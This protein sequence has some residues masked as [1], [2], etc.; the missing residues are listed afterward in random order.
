MNTDVSISGLPPSTANISVANAN[1]SS[2]TTPLPAT[3]HSA[4]LHSA[5]PLPDDPVL[6]QHMIRELLATLSATQRERDGLRER[7]DLILRKLYGPKA[8]RFDPN[9]PLLFPEMN[10]A[11][12]AVP[13]ASDVPPTPDKGTKPKRPGHGRRKLPD[14]L[15][16]ERVVHELPEDKRLCPCCG[17]VQ[18]KF[19]EE[20]SEQLDYVPA[21][22]FVVE[23]VRC[24]YACAKCHEGVTVADKPP[25]PI[26]KGLP[27]PGLLAY[28]ATSKYCDHLPL[29]RL[30][31]IF[32]RHGLELAR[33][34]TCAWMRDIAALLRP[35]VDAMLSLV[36]QSKALHTDAT[37][38]PYQD[39]QRPGK[40]QSGQMWTHVG[41]RDHAFNIF[42]FSPDH[43]GARIRD[44][45]AN[46]NGYLNA[47]AHNIYDS[48]FLKLGQPIL[49]VGCWAHCRRNFFDA[50]TND[51]ARA[52]EVLARIRR[53][54]AIEAEAKNLV[55]QRKLTGLDADAV[56]FLMRQEKS[57][58]EVT[59]LRHW[60]EREQ[61][62]VLPK[63]LIGQAMQY[64]LNHWTALTRFLD[65]GFLALDNNV[66]ENALRAIALGRKNW[67]FAGNANGA[68]T[69]ATL[70]S[71]TS[72]C[73]RHGLDPF[74]YLRD[75]ITR[76]SLDPKPDPTTL[77]ALLP[78]RWRPP[79]TPPP[80]Q[81][82]P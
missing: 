47:D 77:R 78:D 10:Q 53:L 2:T 63:S 32:G 75:L 66:A 25:Q 21:S 20:I 64:A 39:L 11:D 71:L 14:S 12:D 36:L 52:H 17:G 56:V 1:A 29:H 7:I 60:L 59:A 57:T 54:Y 27:G 74:A 68:R 82:P 67:L 13:A 9:Q 38:M 43:S 30:E 79:G 42:D 40:I 31:R 61:P 81:P 24:K 6:L 69:A 35:A 41:D 4:T 58:A 44:V 33:S 50:K 18:H 26:D 73:V 55:A 34:T 19:G 23:H 76:L 22:L 48:L 8:E 37:N 72:S 80:A 3:P 65:D 49:E 16:R 28:I 15:R 70:F 51:P 46:Y 45:L 62:L 5:T